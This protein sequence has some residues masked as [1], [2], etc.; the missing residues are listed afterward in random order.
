MTGFTGCSGLAWGSGDGVA[1]FT[2]IRVNSPGAGGGAGVETGAAFVSGFG[3]V[4]AAWG[5]WGAW[6][7]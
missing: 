4:E 1:A 5:A 3:K 2:K 7:T 6:G